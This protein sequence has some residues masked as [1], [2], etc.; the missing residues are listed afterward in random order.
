[1]LSVRDRHLE[2]VFAGD[3]FAFEFGDLFE[4]VGPHLVEL[5]D[6]VLLQCV[7]FL[8]AHG[9]PLRSVLDLRIDEDG[10]LHSLDFEGAR[11][12]ALGLW[13]P[14]FAEQVHIAAIVFLVRVEPVERERAVIVVLQGLSMLLGLI[15]EGGCEVSVGLSLLALA[16][17]LL[18]L[19]PFLI[20][21]RLG[22]LLEI[23]ICLFFC[24]VKHLLLEFLGIFG[25]HRLSIRFWRRCGELW[26]LRHG[27]LVIFLEQRVI[28]LFTFN[29]LD[30]V[31]CFLGEWIGSVALRCGA[32]CID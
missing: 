18:N 24:L 19:P 21:F 31:V 3:E 27:F 22:G 16:L 8:L 7:F 15:V 23:E 12:E 26:H 30:V 10:A 1:M 25:F 29:D 14:H 5:D 20:H 4:L 32:A 17:V 13:L 2:A 6:H 28:N 11:D 9:L